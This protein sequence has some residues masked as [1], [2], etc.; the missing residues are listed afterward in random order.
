MALNEDKSGNELEQLATEL[1]GLMRAAAS[2]AALARRSPGEGLSIGRLLTETA[3]KS[4]EFVGASGVSPEIAKIA[5]VSPSLAAL[6]LVSEELAKIAHESPGLAELAI[7]SPELARVAFKSPE[8]AH[9]ATSSP[10]LA[11]LLEAALNKL[12]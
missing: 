2:Q 4:A 8:I 3:A 12:K 11:A 10:E 6:T 7:L 5:V 1:L 9:I